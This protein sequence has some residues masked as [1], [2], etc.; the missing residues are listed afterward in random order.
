MIEHVGE[1]GMSS[2]IEEAY[3]DKVEVG[4]LVVPRTMLPI[5][6]FE[7]QKPAE[8]FNMNRTNAWDPS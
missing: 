1:E 6:G 7:C 3:V 8:E 4:A 2:D 5:L